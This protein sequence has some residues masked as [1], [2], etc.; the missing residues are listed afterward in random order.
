MSNSDEI[1]KL[2]I[3]IYDWQNIIYKLQLV[4]HWLSIQFKKFKS[5]EAKQN[6]WLCHSIKERVFLK[7]KLCLNFIISLFQES[8]T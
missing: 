2:D 6:N 7:N 1:M 5:W 3:Y 8:Q 4:W